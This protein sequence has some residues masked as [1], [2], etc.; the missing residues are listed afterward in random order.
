MT[1]FRAG[2][3]TC[4]FWPAVP[5]YCVHLAAQIPIKK[6]LAVTAHVDEL[7]EDGIQDCYDPNSWHG[8]IG[9][10]STFPD[11]DTLEEILGYE[12]ISI[13]FF[14]LW[15]LLRT[16]QRERVNANWQA[17]LDANTTIPQPIRQQT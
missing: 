13:D 4:E 5:M 9:K 3:Q 2:L 6:R 12:P 10:A 15:W 8:L 7:C 14:F 16:E 17:K 1:A 11:E